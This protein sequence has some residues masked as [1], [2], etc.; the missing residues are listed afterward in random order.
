MNV[1]ALAAAGAVSFA[2][3]VGLAA[4]APAED[5]SHWRYSRPVLGE[6]VSASRLVRVA[7][8][9]E[10]F[11]QAQE[12][13]ADLRIVDETGGEVP[14]VQ[15]ARLGRRIRDWQPARTSDEG[16]V[17]GHYTEA[18]VDTG[19]A[20]ALHDALELDTGATDFFHWVELAASDDR[21]TWRI[22]RERAPIYRFAKDG[23]QGNRTIGFPETRARWLRL[24]V[25]APDARFPL[26]GCRVGREIVEEPERIAHPAAPRLDGTVP[27]ESRWEFDLGV[28]RVPASAVRFETAREE[29][30][31]PVRLS[32]SED[33]E[34]WSEIAQ[35]EIYRYR[36]GAAGRTEACARL[37]ADFAEARGRYWRVT[38][39]DRDDPPIDD[40]RAELL[41][42]PR[43]VVFRQEPGRRYTMIY[44]NS[45][46]ARPQYELARLLARDELEAALVVAAGAEQ[47]NDRYVSP[48]PWTE[49]HPLVLWLALGLAV[50]VLA[51]L[52][53]RALR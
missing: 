51:W 37:A 19:G 17:P 35:T 47:H 52:A 28:A 32:V 21:E 38:V 39:V 48:E 33:G 22:V 12:S 36:S 16:F 26:G 5:W 46:V 23:L 10:V 41:G 44:G 14:A 18:L 1:R 49:R 25:L 11:G 45:R 8:P 53:L 40:L 43:Y 15:H 24:R 7:L 6:P 30:H 42:T 34:N 13:L 2:A 20:G 50:A 4:A 29:F 27:R 31:R 9:T 3:G